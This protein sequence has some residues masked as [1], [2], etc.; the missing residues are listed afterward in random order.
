MKDRI[1][2]IAIVVFGAI[3]LIIVFTV[4]YGIPRVLVDKIM[5]ILRTIL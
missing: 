2:E 4:F 1:T 5:A 3:G